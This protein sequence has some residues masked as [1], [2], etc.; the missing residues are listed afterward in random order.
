MSRGKSFA[1]SWRSFEKKRNGNVGGRPPFDV[2]LMMKILVLQSIYNLSDDSRNIIDGC[3]VRPRSIEGWE[4]LF[5]R[6]RCEVQ[7]SFLSKHNYYQS[8]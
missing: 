5:T 8:N 6:C 3:L 2:V 1:P 4:R 7:K